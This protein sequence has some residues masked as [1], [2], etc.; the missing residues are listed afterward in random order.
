[1]VERLDTGV[2]PGSW[3][4]DRLDRPGQRSRD[5]RSRPLQ[6]SGEAALAALDPGDWQPIVADQR[7]GPMAATG[8]DAVIRAR[9]RC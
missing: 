2:G 1:M 8:I 7:P 5:G 4:G 6:V 3:L 9:R